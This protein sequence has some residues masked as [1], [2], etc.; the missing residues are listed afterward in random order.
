MDRPV[1]DQTGITG[2]YDLRLTWT[3]DESQFN[4]RVPPATD[5][6]NAPPGLYT[7]IQEQLGLNLEAVTAPVEVLVIDR[8]ERPSEN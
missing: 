6:P 2:R 4:G 3:P 7:A 5:D 8:V 1:V